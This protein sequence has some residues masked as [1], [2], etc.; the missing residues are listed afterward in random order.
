MRSSP[1]ALHARL[2]ACR[3]RGGLGRAIVEFLARGVDGGYCAR[4]RPETATQPGEPSGHT[5]T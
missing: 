2:S 4:L 3:C 1:A 5:V